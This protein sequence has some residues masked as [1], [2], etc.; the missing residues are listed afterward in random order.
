MHQT[1]DAPVWLAFGLE[2]L[3]T[4]EPDEGDLHVRGHGGAPGKRGTYPEVSSSTMFVAYSQYI[5]GSRSSL[6][7]MISE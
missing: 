7:M 2:S 6:L 1:G 5:P 3:A 4:E